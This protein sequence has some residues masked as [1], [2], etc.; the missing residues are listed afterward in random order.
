M[1]AVLQD[2]D[3]GKFGSIDSARK[4]SRRQCGEV[5]VLSLMSC[6]RE[7]ALWGSLWGSSQKKTP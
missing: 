5:D 3:G 2:C 1:S 7:A 6:I 4:S